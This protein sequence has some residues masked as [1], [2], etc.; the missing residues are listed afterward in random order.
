MQGVI[1]G[2]EGTPLSAL[3]TEFAGDQSAQLDLFDDAA[4][5]PPPSPSE[6]QRSV[7]EHPVLGPVV[8]AELARQRP[9]AAVL[10]DFALADPDPIRRQLLLTYA[11]ALEEKE[12]PISD[13]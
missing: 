2:C 10:S 9:H 3:P 4:A 5:P 6:L 1:Q 8:R 7:L 12:E 11:R 13:V